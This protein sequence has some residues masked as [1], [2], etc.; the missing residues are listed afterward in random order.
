MSLATTS[1]PPDPAVVAPVEAFLLLLQATA[2]RSI[3]TTT[4][5]TTPRRGVMQVLTTERLPGIAS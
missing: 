3:G 1:G 5:E 4:I 2:S